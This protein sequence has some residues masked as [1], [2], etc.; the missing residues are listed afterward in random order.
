MTKQNKID[1]VELIGA[2]IVAILIF[3]FGIA[4]MTLQ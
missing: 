1:W 3:A 4:I 2:P